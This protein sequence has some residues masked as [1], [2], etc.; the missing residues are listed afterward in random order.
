MRLS[1]KVFIHYPAS[2]LIVDENDL[3]TPKQAILIHSWG[4]SGWG[5]LT[6]QLLIDES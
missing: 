4:L 6:G 3:V 5:E 2:L 1:D